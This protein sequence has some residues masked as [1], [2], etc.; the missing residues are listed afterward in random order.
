[1]F[2]VDD[3][4]GSRA[5]LRGETAQHVRKVLRAER[6]QRYEVS[7]GDELWLAEIADFGK[8]LVEFHLLER[9]EAIAPPALLHLYPAL[10]KFDHFEWLLEKATELGAAR[11]TPVYSLRVEKGLDQAAPKRMERWRRILMESG[12]QSR[13]LAPPELNP[14]VKLSEALAAQAPLRLWLEEQRDAPPLLAH[15]P[16]GFESAAMLCGPEGGWDDR[17]RQAAR[18]AGW[19]PVTLGP[20]ILRAETAALAALAV[21]NAAA[22]IDCR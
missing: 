22:L 19:S 6:G 9:I 11:I 14:P 16:R 8:D 7:D 17:E 18:D 20:Q 10:I 5:F 21:L 1:M 2:Y 15:L 13:R 12:Q 3:R 4:D